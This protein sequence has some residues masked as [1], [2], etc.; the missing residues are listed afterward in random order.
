MGTCRLCLKEKKLIKAHII[1]N[2]MYRGIKEG[3]FSRFNKNLDTG[4][5]F[6]LPAQTGEFDKSILCEDC[7]S[8]I[9]NEK[10]EKYAKMTLFDNHIGVEYNGNSFICKNIDY[11]KFKLF[12]LSILWRSSISNR[13]F[14][15]RV[16]L[17]KKLE[18]R[19]RKMLYEGNAPKE[20]EYAI[21]IQMDMD[22]SISTFVVQPHPM[23]SYNGLEA[24]LFLI[25]SL[26]FQFFI[27]SNENNL[28]LEISKYILK[29]SGEFSVLY[30]KGVYKKYLE[31]IIE[32]H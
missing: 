10:F 27:N 9:L 29:E 21:M 17:G 19:L 7:D 2:F 16:N 3:N 26:G 30:L 20:T 28:P 12:L 11:S 13:P 22:S 31:S 24:Y 4:K 14:F 5:S 6:T 18:E 23:G 15:D 1:P 25:N 32:I 8:G